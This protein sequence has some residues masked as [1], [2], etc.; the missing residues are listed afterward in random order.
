VPVARSLLGRQ[1]YGPMI[2]SRAVG[3]GL[4]SLREV[5]GNRDLRRLVLAWG[6]Y[7]LVEWTSLVAVSV[8]AFDEGGTSAVGLL[9]LARFLPAGLAMPA[10][11][12]V[13]DRVPRRA[14]AIGVFAAQAI[15]LLALVVAV[16]DD[17]PIGA[18]AALVA[19]AGI[20]AAPYRPTH[21]ALV[22]LVA[23]SPGELVAA[24][25]A[26]GIAEGTATLLGPV[27]AGVVIGRSGPAAALGVALAAALA[28]LLAVLRVRPAADPSQAARRAERKVTASLLAGARALARNRDL[29]LLVGCF[30]L[31]LLVRGFLSV[32][33][34]PVAIDLLGLEPSG[35]GW[36]SAA[37]G[38]G[39]LAG[40]LLA[41]GLTGRRRFAG[42]A[43]LAL[44]GW[45]LPIGV[46]GVAPAWVV[47]TVVA[48]VVVG[49]SNSV[50]DVSGF[51]LLQRSADDATLG[52]VFGVLYTAGTALA[53]IG[54]L[55][56]PALDRALGLRPTLV[57][58]GLLLP[59]AA[60]TALPR[61]RRIDVSCDV[62]EDA[63][64]VLAGVDLLAGLPTTT[65]E[66]LARRA[67]RVDVAAGSVVVREG[68]VGDAF[69]AIDEGELVVRR[70]G[71]EVAVLGAGGYFGEV[72]LARAAPR[73]AT[74]EARTAARLVRLTGTAFVDGVTSSAAGSELLGQVVER[75]A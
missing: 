13:A 43:A 26:T 59:V 42:V 68:D 32:L 31:Q 37:I 61:L 47:L 12:W 56:A 44:A 50:L 74:V 53:G 6:A 34:V 46:I 62:P 30:S 73:N 29:G 66:K 45:G 54:A 38:L 9:G 7:L 10:G 63:V 49:L 48:L 14:V 52:R 5:S 28:G 64:R 18:V 25:V 17:A 11:G 21:P 33:L 57:V 8:W 4:R 69:Y 40:G 20:A 60:L 75:R 67:E 58:V 72:A 24:N 23:R 22:P 15:V 55:A 35:V 27:V 2:A 3:S 65:I 51:T 1:R 36:L 41:L 71:E 16:A 19:L 70:A 39:G